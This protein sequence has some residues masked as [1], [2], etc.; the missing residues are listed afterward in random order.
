MKK[1][2]AIIAG[3]VAVAMT[4]SACTTNPYTG[5]QKPAS[6]VLALALAQP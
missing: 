4:L 5:S 2:I 6:P 1:R 3:A